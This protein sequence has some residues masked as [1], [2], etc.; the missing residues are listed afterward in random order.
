[1]ESIKKRVTNKK[2]NWSIEDL[3]GDYNQLPLDESDYQIR[4]AETRLKEISFRYLVRRC[5]RETN[6]PR[7]DE[8]RLVEKS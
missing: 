2:T 8:Q 7:R 4:G 3:R 1:L 5:S 6:Q